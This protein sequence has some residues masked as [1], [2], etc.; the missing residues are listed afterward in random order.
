VTTFL[1]HKL[2]WLD[3]YKSVSAVS[4]P[5]RS[6]ETASLQQVHARGGWESSEAQTAG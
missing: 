5:E 6:F 2:K 1:R 4:F 3:K